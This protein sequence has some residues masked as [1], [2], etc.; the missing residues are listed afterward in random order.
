MRVDGAPH[1]AVHVEEECQRHARFVRAARA[2]LNRLHRQGHGR[3]V[4]N[5]FSGQHGDLHIAR[6]RSAGGSDRTRR[7]TS[8]LPAGGRPDRPVRIVRSLD[9]LPGEGRGWDPTT[10]SM[11]RRRRDCPPQPRSFLRACSTRG[12]ERQAPCH[13]RAHILRA[14]WPAHTS[15]VGASFEISIAPMT[16]PAWQGQHTSRL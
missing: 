15:R 10:E 5:L 7:R 13:A 6:R 16:R 12:S 8:L 2:R 9:R 4:A 14:R 1:G 3:T 11:R